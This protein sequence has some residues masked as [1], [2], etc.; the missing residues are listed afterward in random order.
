MARKQRILSKR[1]KI[2]CLDACNKCYCALTV[3][4][5]SGSA[6]VKALIEEFRALEDRSTLGAKWAVANALTVVADA[7]VAESI[8]ELALDANHGEARRPLLALLSEFGTTRAR[9]ALQELLQ[10]PELAG[11]ARAALD[12]M[13]RD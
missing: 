6:A 13:T 7:Q 9:S 11:E 4:E 12:R 8:V 5:A 2:I 3:K 1:S 10:D